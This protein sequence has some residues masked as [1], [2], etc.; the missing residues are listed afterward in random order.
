MRKFLKN[1]TAV[2]LLSAMPVI[3]GCS[4]EDIPEDTTDIQSDITDTEPVVSAAEFNGMILGT[5]NNPWLM[6][7]VEFPISNGEFVTDISHPNL[8]GQT[9]IPT[10][11]YT[12]EKLLWNG[13]E[14]TFG[15]SVIINEVN[16]V[17]IYDANGASSEYTVKVTDTDHN[18]PTVIIDANGADIPDKLNYVDAEISVIGSDSDIYSAV[19][20]IKLRGNSTM[21]YEKKPYRIK[22]DEKQEVLGIAKAKSWVLLANY[23]DPASMRGELAFNFAARVN[24]N[25]AET[26]GHT[27]FAPRMKPV[28]VYLNGEYIGLYDMGDHMQAD[29]TR[30]AI[31]ESGD[32]GSTETDIG[33]LIEVEVKERVLL[34]GQEGYED[35]SAYSYIENVGASGN[36]QNNQLYFQFKLPEEPTDEQ[37]AYITDYMQTVNDLILASDAAVLDYIDLDSFVDWYIVNELFKNTDSLMQSSIYLHKDK[38]GKLFMGPVW[39]FD[40]STGSQTAYDLEDPEGY[41]TKRDDH[42][43]W[44]NALYEMEAFN[45]ALTSRWSELREKDIVDTIFTDMDEFIEYAGDAA[46]ADYAIWHESYQ[47]TFGAENA[48]VPVPEIAL[49]GS[50]SEQVE[51]LRDFLTKRIAWLDGEFGYGLPDSASN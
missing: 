23:L 11:S 36:L 4:P 37:I 10:F 27:V 50:Y 40:L 1:I 21:G 17:T 26:T 9:V 33:Y 20:G 28:E 41:W 3:F 42:C 46:E 14:Y 13:E 39:D 51:Y 8:A 44:F 49:N 32:D 31:D 35:W 16:T 47:R 24:E 15:D 6:W 2:L 30:V 7:E 22:F 38:G 43:G 5:G 18:I 19:A 12:G 29:K 34:E 45:S 48:L 25:T